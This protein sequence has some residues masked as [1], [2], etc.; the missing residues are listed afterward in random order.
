MSKSYS[1]L[2]IDLNIKIVTRN[3]IHIYSLHVS[4]DWC[5]DMNIWLVY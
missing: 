5:Y 2:W 3:G 1:A 4:F